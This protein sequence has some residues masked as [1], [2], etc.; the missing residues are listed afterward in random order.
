MFTEEERLTLQ[1]YQ[2][3]AAAW[4]GHHNTAGIWQE[5]IDVFRRLLP[6]GRILEVGCGGGRDARDLMSLGYQYFGCDVVREFLPVAQ[7]QN[8]GG[9][10][11]QASLYELPIPP[12]SCDGFWA[13]AVLLHI[14]KTR[15]ISVMSQLHT[16]LRN[17][18]VGFI[19]VKAGEGEAVIVETEDDMTLQRLFSFY[20]DE[21]FVECLTA[22][23]FRIEH[24]AV[25]V[26]GR[27]TWLCYIV[28][29]A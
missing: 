16:A 1:S 27:T 2:A 29:K 23:N 28:R 19:A 4:A 8:P 9:R 12:G 13:S 24:S 11:F 7:A 17:D 6:T 26:K 18:G 3:N 5:S 14:P 20:S 21:E 22:S 25:K 15:I 10:F